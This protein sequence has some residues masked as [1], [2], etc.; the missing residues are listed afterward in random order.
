MIGKAKACVGGTSLIGY[1]ID[2]KKGYELERSNLSGQTPSELYRS[3]QV[4]QN[5][6]L[7]C[8]NNTISIVL[9]PEIDDGKKLTTEQWKHLS[10]SAISALGVNPEDAQYI[11]FI[12]TEK[13]HKHLHI[14]LNR[15]QDDGKLVK[16]S[17]IGKRMQH[18]AHNLALDM[19]LVSAKVIKEEKQSE[20]K[21]L[22][23]EFRADFRKAHDQV[24]ETYPKNLEEY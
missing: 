9:S 15:V 4:I 3:M 12:H 5:Q 19:N 24:S 14:I 13:E 21:E 23:K 11:S 16:D 8:K 10:K 6:N 2:Q 20:R 1:V 17:Y 7:R 18:I 22:L